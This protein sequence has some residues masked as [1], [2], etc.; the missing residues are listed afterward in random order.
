M[1]V[2][3]RLCALVAIVLGGTRT[4]HA[5]SSY[6][7]TNLVSDL[8]TEGAAIVDP[9]LK[10]PWGVS[11]SPTSPFWISNAGSN[12]TQLFSDAGGTVSQVNLTVTTPQAGTPNGGPTGQVSVPTGSSG[13][14]IPAA[15]GGNVQAAGTR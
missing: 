11:F 1:R 12:T 13:F 8:S 14:N 2:S 9:N 7:Q 6:A 15:S 4:V 5:G 10:N 3:L